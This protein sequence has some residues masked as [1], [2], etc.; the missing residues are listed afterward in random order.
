MSTTL[1]AKYFRID[2][3]ATA[4]IND[5]DYF[6][7][8]RNQIMERAR[9]TKKMVPSVAIRYLQL[10]IVITKTVGISDAYCFHSQ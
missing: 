7:G 8:S 9:E 6:S 1:N 10:S 5:L 2:S 4:L 3:G